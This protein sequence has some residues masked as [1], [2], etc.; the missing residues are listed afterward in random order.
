MKK[1]LFLI[2]LFCCFSVVNAK[3]YKIEQVTSEDQINNSTIN[4]YIIVNHADNGNYYAWSSTL[5]SG[6]NSKRAQAKENAELVTFN[7]DFTELTVES[8]NNILWTFGLSAKSVSQGL[9]RVTLVSRE[10]VFDDENSNKN[11]IAFSSTDTKTNPAGFTYTNDAYALDFKFLN[12]E[13]NVRI[14]YEDVKNKRTYYVRFLSTDNRFLAGDLGKASKKIKIYKVID[15]YEKVKGFE[16][17][18]SGKLDFSKTKEQDET[19]KTTGVYKI[20]LSMKSEP[21]LK[22]SDIMFVLDISNSMDFDDK[23]EQLKMNANYLADS[24]LKMNSNN[25]IGVVK[26]ADGN[27][28]VDESYELGLSN[29]LID[30]QDLINEDVEDKLGGTNYTGAFDLAYEILKENEESGREQVVIFITDGAPTIY[31]KTKFSVFKN[32]DD[33]IVGEYAENWSNYFLNNK[34]GNLEKMKDAG[35]GVFTIGVNLDEDMAIKSDG[36][37]VVKSESAITLLKR[38]ATSEEYFFMVDDYENLGDTFDEIY[39]SLRLYLTQAVV[40]DSIVTNYKLVVENYEGKT[41]YVEIKNESG[42]V[43]ERVEFSADG[44]KAYSSLNPDNNII[45]KEENGMVLGATYFSYNFDTKEL[46]WNVD[47]V[48]EDAIS[49]TYFIKPE[50]EQDF[51]EDDQNAISSKVVIDYKD[52]DIE[53]KQLVV[54][55][56]YIEEE[57]NPNTVSTNITLLIIGFIISLCIGIISI[58]KKRWLCK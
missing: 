22:D 10:D 43:V 17:N 32:T 20:N 46:V 29:D 5:L 1:I 54:E 40:N 41:P 49:L 4:D 24:L 38:M 16:N 44:T 33:G 12:D 15:E 19:F 37:F 31:N 7:D 58:N 48:T 18:S 35:I 13:G 6:T 3:T 53:E 14:I 56:P 28:L 30:I 47:E 52:Y 27:L 36:S 25:R 42:L 45:V 57:K 9:D 51:Y 39:S 34:L 21:L 50:K 23:M 26:F 11:Q 2:S 8:D 55:T